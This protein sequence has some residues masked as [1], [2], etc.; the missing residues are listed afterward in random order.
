MKI[1][2]RQD[3]VGAVVFLI[4][5]I[6]LWLLIPYQIMVTDDEEV[7]TAQTFPRLVIGLMGICSFI[8]LVKELV[9]WFRKQPVKMVE[10]RFDQELRSLIVIA[11]LLLYWAMLNWLPFMIASMIFSILLLLFFRCKNWIYYAIVIS[12][13]ISVS[14]FFQYVL[15]VSL[16]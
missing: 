5:S 15:N 3:L 9:K 6:S 1:S 14:V 11:L 12:V 8:L 4:L 10:L 16:P 13:V 7:I 2:F